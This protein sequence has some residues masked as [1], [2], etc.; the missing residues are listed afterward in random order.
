[1]L[2]KLA[3][4]FAALAFAVTGVAMAVPAGASTA[5]PVHHAQQARHCYWYHG[6]WHCYG[7]G[8][9]GG[10]DHDHGDHDRGHHDHDH[11]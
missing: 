9:Y 3:A 7:G 5:A 10:H 4:I 1:M 8:Y 2:A 11:H 6:W